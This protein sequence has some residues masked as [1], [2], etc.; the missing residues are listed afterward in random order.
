MSWWAGFVFAGALVGTFIDG[1]TRVYRLQAWLFAAP[2]V[3]GFAA[4]GASFL[5]SIYPQSQ[6]WTTSPTFFFVRVAMVAG[7]LPVAYAWEHAPWRGVISRWSPVVEMGRSSL[8]VYW[9]HVEMVYGVVSR[10]LRRALPLEL[11]VL[12][13]LLFSAFILTLVLLKNS[14][15]SVRRTGAVAAASARGASI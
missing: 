1:A 11:A 4:Y 6:Y 7:L 10:P 5:P 12:A 13:D 14:I 8:F 15:V 2:V 9:I 3:L